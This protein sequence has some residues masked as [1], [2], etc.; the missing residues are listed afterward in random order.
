MG[1][2]GVVSI[3]VEAQGVSITIADGS[4]AIEQSKMEIP[5]VSA[6][7]KVESPAAAN[8]ETV[9]VSTV[10]T[11]RV[12]PLLKGVD[13]S[14]V[15]KD[16]EQ[17]PD[18]PSSRGR[19]GPGR[20]PGA[21]EA[22]RDRGHKGESGGNHA[23]GD[24]DSGNPSPRA[25][26]FRMRLDGTSKMKYPKKKMPAPKPNISAV[27]QSSLFIVSAAN[28]ALTGSRTATT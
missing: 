2:N 3:R 20:K 26:P 16:F 27:R 28:P 5:A 14:T 18:R 17:T 1:S 25:D 19:N 15:R 4:I 9:P 8:S 11:E 21:L 10:I 7:P 6:A 12:P 13:D 22:R 23:L 24:H